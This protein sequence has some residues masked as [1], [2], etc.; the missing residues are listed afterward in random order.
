MRAILRGVLAGAAIAVMFHSAS[1]G[2][3]DP[4]RIGLLLSTTGVVGFIGDPEQKAVELYVKRVNDEGGVLGRKIELVSYD[5][6]SEPARS[7]SLAKRLI[8]TDHVDLIIGGTVTPTAMAMIPLVERAEV[9]YISVG[10]GLPIVDPV[11]KW[12]FKTPHT[13]RQVAQRILQDMKSRGYTKVGLLSETAGFGQSGRKEVMENAESYGVT[14]IAD[15]KYGP[16]DTDVTPQLATIKSAKG[17]EA[18]LIFCGAGTSPAM[19]VKNYARLDVKLPLYLPHAVV[20]QEFLNL[21]GSASEGARMPTAIFVVPEGVPVED[22]QKRVIDAFYRGYK[23]AYR[24]VA[25]PFAG[26]SYDAIA[27]AIDALRRAG[28]TDKAKVRQAI[29]ETR[30]LAGLNGVFSMSATDHLGLPTE[31]LRMHVV[32]DGKF[33]PVN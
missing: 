22:P 6:A 13:D 18:V 2:A 32:K 33:L 24:E 28:T 7:S 3:E 4:I 30:G 8:E 27:I 1:V 17:I 19:A 12:V 10:G 16:K 21:T 20:S 11:K 23:E 9:P 25:S 14:I 29:E 5:D 15:E 31:S 26:N